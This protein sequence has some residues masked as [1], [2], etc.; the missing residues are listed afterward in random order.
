[1]T[2]EMKMLVLQAKMVGCDLFVGDR[3]TLITYDKHGEVDK[4]YHYDYDA[5]YTTRIQNRLNDIARPLRKKWG[6]QFL[7]L[8]PVAF[9]LG[10]W[11]NIGDYSATLMG[12]TNSRSE[13]S[14]DEIQILECPFSS[15]GLHKMSDYIANIF[16][17]DQTVNNDSEEEDDIMDIELSPELARVITIMYYRM[18]A[19]EQQDLKENADA[20]TVSIIKQALQISANS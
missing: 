5:D 14:K 20:K 11:I 12:T 6:E 18:S 2:K 16:L 9:S 19:K 10:Y 1:M 7:E 3:I 17:G 13:V 4:K 8:S 15:A